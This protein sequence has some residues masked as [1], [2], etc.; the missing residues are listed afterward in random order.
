[1]FCSIGYIWW[2]YAFLIS[3]DPCMTFDPS[4]ALYSSQ[5]FF[6][7][8]MVANW[9]QTDPCMTFDPSNALHFGQVFFWPNLV[10]IGHFWTIWPLVD[11][12]WHLDD[13]W[14]QQWV[15]LW[16]RVVPTKFGGHRIFLS[17]LTSGWPQMTSAW[18]LTSNALRSGQ[19]FF[20]LNLV[21]IGHS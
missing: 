13:L 4:N 6:L 3:A 17:N 8:N 16:S 12:R 2:P 19:G 14:P 18:P 15:T 1:M 20:P 21:P 5:G 9:P 10:P 11:P 7:T